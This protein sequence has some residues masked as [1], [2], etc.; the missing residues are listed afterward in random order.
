MAFINL[1]RPSV[2]DATT[3]EFAEGVIDNL[4]ELYTS[5]EAVSSATLKN[6]SFEV[7][8]GGLPVSWTPTIA[9][10][11]SV[12]ISTD[13]QDGVYSAKL[14]NPAGTTGPVTLVSESYMPVGVAASMAVGFYMK[15]TVASGISNSVSV[16]YYGSGLSM[17]STD[18]LYSSVLNPTTWNKYGF[19]STVPS[20]A[21]FAKLNL[22][23]V[24]SS[25]IGS[26]YFDGVTFEK[27]QTANA[28]TYLVSGYYTP[29]AGISKIKIRALGGGGGGGAGAG[30]GG[31]NGGNGGNGGDGGE[32]SFDSRYVGRG[33][34]GGIGSVWVVDHSTNANGGATKNPVISGSWIQYGSIG[35]SAGYDGG[36][37]AAGGNGGASPYPFILAGAVGGNA[38]GS[39]GLANMGQGGGGGGSTYY[40]DSGAGGGG[41][42]GEYA[43]GIVFISGGTYSI[44][45]G[46]GG[47]AG[48]GTGT[49]GLAGGAGGSGMLVI[50]EI[51]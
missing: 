11:K 35:G 12:S 19:I 27:S 28:Y 46:S 48:T 20:G 10:G 7:E 33:G 13:S 41:A 2:G 37:N 39:S 24:D 4:N 44:V 42:G 6:G 5:V 18:T 31:L 22:V 30:S 21:R 36:A 14:D 29:T 26:T 17:V 16:T 25:V 15:S 45:V 9:A 34:N 23:G 47:S 3:T 51:C 43:E 40:Y 8:S 49:G 50:E 38:V 1:N 32:T